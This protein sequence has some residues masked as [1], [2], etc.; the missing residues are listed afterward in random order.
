MQ[1]RT[2]SVLLPVVIRHLR[3]LAA[4][5]LLSLTLEVEPVPAAR[6]RVGRWGTYYPKTYQKFQKAAAAALEAHTGTPA[7]GPI[8]AVVETV[9]KC[10][11]KPTN[12]YPIGDV[13]NFAKGPLDSMTKA[14]KFWHDDKQIIDLLT[15]KRYAEPGETP[16]IHIH[17]YEI[18]ETT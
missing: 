14:V 5:A 9:A 11:A 18:P 15:T 12:P 3:K 16:C 6:P 8:V 17:W 1:T 7:A 13:D 10:P 2:S 4:A